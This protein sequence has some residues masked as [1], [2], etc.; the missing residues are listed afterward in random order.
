MYWFE[1]LYVFIFIT[2]IINN[3]IQFINFYCAQ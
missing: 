3:D 2:M 1:M